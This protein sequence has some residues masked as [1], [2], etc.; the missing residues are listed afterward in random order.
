METTLLQQK[1]SGEGEKS[2]GSPP[3]LWWV[4]LHQAP[5][6][7]PGSCCPGRCHRHRVGIWSWRPAGQSRPLSRC[8]PGFLTT[9]TSPSGPCSR[10]PTASTRWGTLL[11][12]SLEFT[13]ATMP[14]GTRYVPAVTGAPGGPEGT[15]GGALR[16]RVPAAH[17]S[18]HRRRLGGG[19]WPLLVASGC[20]RLGIPWAVPDLGQCP[21]PNSSLRPG[22]CWHQHPLS[23]TVRARLPG[24][25]PFP[26]PG[27]CLRTPARVPTE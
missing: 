4:G 19:S 20:S 15:E 26:P 16:C 8:F 14:G 10:E 21:G 7:S 12:V 23:P 17:L 18:C 6:S 5:P 9:R 24:W 2:R 11:T 3:A 13:N 1:T 25:W 27:L 22:E